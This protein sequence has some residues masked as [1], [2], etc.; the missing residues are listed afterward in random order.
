MVI[1][2]EDILSDR[3]L[4]YPVDMVLLAVGLE[5]ADGADEWG[6]VL[7]IGC[8]EEGWFRELD[9]NIDPTGTERGG[10]YVAGVCQGPKDIPDTVAQAAAV[11]ARVLRSLVSGRGRESRGSVPLELIEQRARDLAA[12]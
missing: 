2:G 7:G 10:I 9:Y 4:E 6:Q 5:P 8:D 1:K 12:R 11:A 3:V